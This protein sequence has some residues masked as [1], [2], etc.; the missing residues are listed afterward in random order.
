MKRSVPLR[1]CISFKGSSLIEVVLLPSHNRS[2]TLLYILNDW[3]YFGVG[4]VDVEFIQRG[5]P[6][7]LLGD[8]SYK[9]LYNSCD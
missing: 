9:M 7:L 6:E 1:D 8:F 4:P 2:T 5:K 3:A